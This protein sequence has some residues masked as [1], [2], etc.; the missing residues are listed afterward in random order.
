MKEAGFRTKPRTEV[1]ADGTPG[2]NGGN[3]VLSNGALTITQK[4]QGSN[5][6]KI[7]N[8]KQAAPSDNGVNTDSKVKYLKERARG[9]YIPSVC[10]PDAA[11]D[12]SI[13]TQFYKPSKRDYNAPSKRLE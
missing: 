12:L 9:A 11:F 7:G 2:F 5:I 6:E 10:Q 13:A 1:I 3:L 8:Q 4:G